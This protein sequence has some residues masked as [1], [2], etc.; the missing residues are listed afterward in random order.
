MA[1]V[2]R[3]GHRHGGRD[4]WKAGS[5]SG[6]LRYRPFLLLSALP[7]ILLLLAVRPA[8]PATSALWGDAAAGGGEAV[9]TPPS[10][11]SGAFISKLPPRARHRGR[12]GPDARMGALENGYPPDVY[13]QAVQDAP[14]TLDPSYGNAQLHEP[15]PP[16]DPPAPPNYKR[17]DY[18]PYT[19]ADT[20]DYSKTGGLVKN[21]CR[22][23]IKTPTITKLSV[24]GSWLLPPNGRLTI[25]G[26]KLGKTAI[27][28]IVLVT[29]NGKK[30]KDVR[31]GVAS[32]EPEPAGGEAE[33]RSAAGGESESESEAADDVGDGPQGTFQDRAREML[34]LPKLVVAAA[35]GGE[36]EQAYGKQWE[37][38]M[39]NQTTGAGA[40]VTG[41]I[42]E[43]PPTIGSERVWPF[44]AGK[45]C[46]G[47][48]IELVTRDLK[49]CKVRC[50]QFPSCKGIS[51][52][53]SD[54]QCK[55]KTGSCTAPTASDFTFYT[56]HRDPTGADGGPAQGRRKADNVRR[57]GV[58]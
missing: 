33:A 42:G 39:G 4:G 29:V 25:Y 50:K 2:Q 49:G 19:S 45:D 5:V 17:S 57:T 53:A 26:E 23:H 18:N 56:L 13:A 28:D 37:E 46:V 7:T 6:F 10:F 21:P 31:L 54:G 44:D 47:N 30:C 8:S 41:R 22:A 27:G 48:D 55:P 9:S 40:R 14:R 24:A 34:G 43:P 38:W 52:R 35:A 12:G 51:H 32:N 16:A 58:V 11:P 36:A 3:R 1:V 20:R 15:K